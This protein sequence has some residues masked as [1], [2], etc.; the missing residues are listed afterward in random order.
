MSA[1]ASRNPPPA[2][3]SRAAEDD[4]LRAARA[5]RTAWLLGLLALA[6]YVGFMVLTAVEGPR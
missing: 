5:R 1:R 6:F 3:V 2:E 4:A